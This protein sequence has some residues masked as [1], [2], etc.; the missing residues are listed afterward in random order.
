MV[1]VGK[2]DVAK[3]IEELVGKANDEGTSGAA[4]CIPR[5]VMVARKPLYGLVFETY[6]LCA[7][8]KNGVG[9]AYAPPHV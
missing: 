7:D 1:K 4:L 8:T 3:S 5:V 9:L 6:F 2:I